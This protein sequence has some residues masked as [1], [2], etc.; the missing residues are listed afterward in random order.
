MLSNYMNYMSNRISVDMMKQAGIVNGYV[1]T[2][3]SIL[4]D[5]I[6]YPWQTLATSFFWHKKILSITHIMLSN[7]TCQMKHTWLRAYVWESGT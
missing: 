5:V 7:W 1:I 3:H 2:S 4:H 6:A